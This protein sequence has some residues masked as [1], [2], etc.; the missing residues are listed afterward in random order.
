MHED[1]VALAKGT[2]ASVKEVGSLEDVD[3]VN[4]QSEFPSF[5]LGSG[6]LFVG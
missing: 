5:F 6:S 1:S 3:A 2:G 4:R